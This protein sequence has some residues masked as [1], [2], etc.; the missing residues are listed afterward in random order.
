MVI[1]NRK[2]TT[3]VAS[4]KTLTNAVQKKN[5]FFVSFFGLNISEK[6]LKS[7]R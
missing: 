2:L 3:G 7:F 1:E 5:Y 6:V 4:F